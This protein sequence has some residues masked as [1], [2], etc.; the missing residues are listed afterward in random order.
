[1]HAAAAAA[2]APAAGDPVGAYHHAVSECRRMQERMQNDPNSVTDVMR[3]DF[4]LDSLATSMTASDAAEYVTQTRLPKLVPFI[5][6]VEECLSSLDQYGLTSER[7][8]DC[9]GLARRARMR[10]N[11]VESDVKEMSV[12]ANEWY[13]AAINV[14]S[15]ISDRSMNIDPARMFQALERR[16]NTLRRLEECVE[17][18]EQIHQ[19][20]ARAWRMAQYFFSGQAARDEDARR[21]SVTRCIKC[22]YKHPRRSQGGSR[23]KRKPRKTHRRR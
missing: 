16:K 13:F 20:H 17:V 4:V 15:D 18:S 5:H 23:K 10:S 12:A 9:L 2:A 22:E 21:S 1:M 6:N 11:E 3:R 14:Y 19:M 7:C 8:D